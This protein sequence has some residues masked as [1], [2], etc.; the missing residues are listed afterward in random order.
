MANFIWN[1]ERNLLIDQDDFRQTIG[2]ERGKYVQNVYTE[3]YLIGYVENKGVA[4]FG[5]FDTES[6]AWEWARQ[7][8]P[9]CEPPTKELSDCEHCMHS[10]KSDCPNPLN[11]QNCMN[12]KEV[13]TERREGV[14]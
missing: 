3:F 12:F 6:E 8:I 7:N 2:I 14:L 11:P 9:I 4:D 10:W 13:D 1:K 5:T